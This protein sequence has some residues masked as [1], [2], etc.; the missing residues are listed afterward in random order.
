MI[1]KRDKSFA[2]TRR[3]LLQGAFAGVPFL[4]LGVSAAHAGKASAGSVGYRPSPKG[5]QNCANCK[6]FVSPNACK[7]VS[8]EISANGWCRIWKA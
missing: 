8:G 5:D 6:L 7:S 3:G 4:G 1:D 2:A